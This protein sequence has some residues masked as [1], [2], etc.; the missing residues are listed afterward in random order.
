MCLHQLI[1]LGVNK[2]NTAATIFGTTIHN[3]FISKFPIFYP[4]NIGLLFYSPNE[5]WLKTMINVAGTI[6]LD[7]ILKIFLIIILKSSINKNLN[8]IEKYIIKNNINSNGIFFLPYLN[9]GGVIAPF[10]NENAS[11]VIYGLNHDHNKYNIIQ[12]SL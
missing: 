6:N 7:W 9:H 10:F 1:G 5:L 2:E 3:C 4:K 11:G 12:I 8:Q